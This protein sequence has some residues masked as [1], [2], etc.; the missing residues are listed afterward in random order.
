LF[1]FVALLA[2]GLAASSRVNS[3]ADEKGEKREDKLGDAEK[4]TG[5]WV[6]VS[7]A[8]DGEEVD[9]ADIKK[10]KLHLVIKKDELA[11][12]AGTLTRSTSSWVIDSTKQPKQITLTGIEPVKGRK[13]LAIY[14]LEGDTLKL[15]IAG[16]EEDRPTKF[17]TK[18]GGGGILH[19][20]R[21]DKKQ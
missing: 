16:P 1:T 6:V 17:E 12:L 8:F 15:C 4:L 19:V 5:L 18:R 2:L 20:L 11:F 14:E 21:R 3:H 13:V 9:P 10:E 7:Q